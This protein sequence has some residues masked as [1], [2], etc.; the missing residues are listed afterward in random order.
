MN[1]ENGI[2][3][4][5]LKEVGYWKR[6]FN[7]RLV[8]GT[9]IEFESGNGSNSDTVRRAIA[10]NGLG[11][12]FNNGVDT[13]KPDGSLHCGAEIT[14]KPRFVQSFIQMFTGY[15]HIINDI[16][17][18]E[19]V[20]KTRAGWHNH[21]SLLANNDIIG[22][23]LNIPE[24]IVKNIIT[25]FKLYYPALRYF[26][27]TMPEE[28][29]CITRFDEFCESD[30][31]SEF[32]STNTLTESLDEMTD[33]RYEALNLRGIQ[34]EKRKISQFRMETRFPDCSVF[35]LQMASYNI[36]CKAIILK[37]VELS[38]VGLID[39]SIS[40]EVENLYFIAN[41]YIEHKKNYNREIRSLFEGVQEE[42]SRASAML[43]DNYMDDIK[44]MGDELLNLL[45]SEIDNIDNKAYK[46]VEMVMK[47]P[48]SMLFRELG[49]NE[50]RV[51]NEHYEEIIDNDYE[52][53]KDESIEEVSKLIS[54][55][56]VKNVV[57]PTQWI[58]RVSSCI[59]CKEDITKIITKIS[60]IRPMKFS[61]E[62][63][64][65]FV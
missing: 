50:V 10:S 61:C 30:K 22:N 18:F 20:I 14:T 7:E 64:Y 25:L 13:V 40:K 44:A 41:S 45:K 31:L 28:T 49:T 32:D 33:E 34:F 47:T 55:E 52:S 62:R 8:I 1:F 21:I 57:S 3:G 11:G 43:K 4:L 5:G 35:P 37:A 29:G 23:E 58:D 60:K 36:L 19:P 26:T 15:N 42:Y 38:H 27:S 48:V 59:S 53:E 12:L 63:G 54:L 65:Y 46:Y 2:K 16:Y 9:E 56:K 24:V 39:S 51:I 17:E 6:I